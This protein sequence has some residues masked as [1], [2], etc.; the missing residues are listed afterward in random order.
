M[1]QRFLS[2][3]LLIALTFA[4]LLPAGTV[5]RAEG[6]NTCGETMYWSFSGD[7]LTITGSGKMDDF[8]EEA[9]WSAYKDDIAAV[10]LDGEITYI[11]ARA[12]KNYDRLELVDFGQDL[13]EIGE[14]AFYS[15]DGLTAISLPA[16]F[17][18]FG[19]SSFLGCGKLKEIHCA[20]R[21]PSFRQNCLWDTYATIYYPAENP[22][23]VSTIA[24]LETAFH[25]RIEF[26]A[27]DGTDPYEP[28]EATAEPTETSVP[29]TTDP[30]EVT[31]EPTEASTTPVA[32]ATQSPTQPVT[33][34]TQAQT[35]PTVPEVTAPSPA[36]EPDSSRLSA[37]LIILLAVFSFLIGGA[38]AFRLAG[39]RGRY[40]SRRKKR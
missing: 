36:Q 29:P 5:A 27:S 25:G 18:V 31:E 13:Y 15:C 9:P 1:K 3:L 37:P 19:P 22:W 39:N 8:E 17:K 26:L 21:F 2:V 4:L 7:T 30:A 24:E 6:E 16:S 35:Q 23:P 40:K 11:G 38:L 34:A 28:T 32:E 33:E 14:E 20:G 10:I 12:F